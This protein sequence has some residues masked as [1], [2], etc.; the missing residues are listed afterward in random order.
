MDIQLIGSVYGTAS[1]ICSYMCKGESEEVK[2]VI[3]DAL[4]TLPANASIRKKLSQVGNTMLSHRELS[5]QEA[6]YRLGNLPLKDSTR[7]VVFVNTVGPEKRTRLLKSRSELFELGDHHTAIF[8]PGLFDRYAARPKG[9]DFEEM[10]L[11]YFSVW[12]D[13][14]Q[15]EDSRKKDDYPDGDRNL[16]TSCKI[17]WVGSS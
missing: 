10:T 6:A 16:D 11:A 2:K 8:Q 13:T 7:K 1:Y 14:I 4:N 9:D 12:Y 3:R 5:A 17:I 15:R